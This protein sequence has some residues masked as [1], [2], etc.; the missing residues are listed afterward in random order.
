MAVNV[1]VGTHTAAVSCQKSPQLASVSTPA[2]A[3]LDLRVVDPGV[4][5]FIH[6]HEGRLDSCIMRLTTSYGIHIIV[7]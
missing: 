7:I 5:R 3:L 1:S 4:F 2:R 6:L